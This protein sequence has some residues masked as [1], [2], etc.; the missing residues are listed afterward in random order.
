MLTVKPNREEVM[1]ELQVMELQLPE[2]IERLRA[3]RKKVRQAA[4]QM[5]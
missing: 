3:Q 2:D 4:G 1:E 5:R